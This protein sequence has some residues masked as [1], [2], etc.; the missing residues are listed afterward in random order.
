MS[1]FFENLHEKFDT[2]FSGLWDFISPLIKVFLT[3]T[4]NQLKDIALQVVM[5]IAKDPPMVNSGGL[6]KRQAAF[7]KIQSTLQ[8]RGLQVATSVINAA[9]EASVQKIASEGAKV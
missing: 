4:G 3:E 5:D 2:M 6:A 1:N 8:A 9:I 7:D